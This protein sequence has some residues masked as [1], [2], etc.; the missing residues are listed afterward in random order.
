VIAWPW[1]ILSTV[2]GLVA[3]FTLARSVWFTHDRLDR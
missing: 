3:G 1:L 2:L